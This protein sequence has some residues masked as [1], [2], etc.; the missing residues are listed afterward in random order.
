DKISE[1]RKDLIGN[2]LKLE[3]SDTKT[4]DGIQ[5]TPESFLPFLLAARYTASTPEQRSVFAGGLAS[6]L[7]AF[8]DTRRKDLQDVTDSDDEAIS[9]TIALS[10]RDH[11]YLEQIDNAI[12]HYKAKEN[13]PHPKV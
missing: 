5:T 12:G 6:S 10:S 1:R 13:S 7:E 4:P 2:A 8:L 3:E 9:S 11:W